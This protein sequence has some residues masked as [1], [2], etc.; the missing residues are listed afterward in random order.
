MANVSEVG[1]HAGSGAEPAFPPFDPHTFASTIFWLIITFGALYFALARYAL[2]RVQS[3]LRTRSDNIHAN[4]AAARTMRKEAEDAAAAYEK[5]LGEAKARSQALAHESRE[6][7]KL[8]QQAKRQSLEA[9][10]D[11]KLAA[12]EV[13]IAETKASAMS[14]VGQIAR[15]ATAAIIQHVSGQAADPDVVAKAVSQAGV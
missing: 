3:I 10:L 2:P 12:A 7:V 5:T 6:K 8:E 1:A 4:L 14:N 13:R 15:E 11:Q 9:E